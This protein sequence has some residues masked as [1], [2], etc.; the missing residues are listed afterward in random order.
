M[1]YLELVMR[2]T[3]KIK[4]KSNAS[5]L[6]RAGLIAGVLVA[7]AA[8]PLAA[9]LGLVAKTGADLLN[10]LPNE[11]KL[12]PPAQTSYVYAS[13]GKT[14]LTTFYEEHRKY[15]PMSDMSPYILQAIVA[16][17]DSRFYQHGGVDP[18]GVV[19]AFVANQQAGGVSQGAST[20]TMQFV[21]ATLRDGAES[22][23]QVRAATA[24]T[25]GRKVRE[26]RLAMEL[27]K[28]LSKP[29]ILERYLNAAYYGHRAYGI[30]AAAEVF[31]SKH[32][33][34]LNLQEAALLAGLVKAPTA[35]DP[36]SS[37]QKAATDRRNYVI[38]RMK[39]LAYI[40][41]E[42]ATQAK[43]DSIK[44][45]LSMPPNDCAS[46]PEDR[47]SWGFFCDYLKN[48]WV[49]QPAFGN[50]PA[51]REN[52]LNRG[53]YK[54]VLSLDPKI[55]EDAMKSVLAK[56]STSSSY[57]HGVV[58]V[59]PR[60]GLVKTMAVNRVYSLDQ[61]NN[62]SHSDPGL[63]GKVRGNYPNTV[64]A[65]LGGGSLPGYQAGSTFKMFTMLAALN[66]G[67]KLSTAYDSPH[68]Y[69]SIYRTGGGPCGE[70]WCPSNASAAM[71]GRQDMRSGFGKSVNTYFVQLLQSV[72]A[73]KA[74][75]MAER[76]GL[77]WHTDVDKMM[78][79]PGRANNWG[80]FTLGVADTTP[81]EMAN[82]YAAV[83][84]D[85]LYCE[86]LPVL[87]ITNPD[88]SPAMYTNGEGNSVPVAAPRCSQAFSNDAARAATEAARCVTA[89]IANGCGGWSTA[90]QVSGAVGRP[91]AGKTGT[92]DDTRAAWFVGY[93]P[94]LAAASFI[95]D[96]DNPF[97]VVGDGN[98]NKPIDTVSQTLKEAL[99]GRPVTQF[100][101]PPGSIV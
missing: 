50:S 29:E 57:A 58:A 71:T 40:S 10:G 27:E 46:V 87:S 42:T 75:R 31:F 69:Q 30:Y 1:S 9:A 74:V 60:T 85:G 86:A 19:R 90:S 20:L 98:A 82:A 25:P 101:A 17:E 47:N 65:L 99:N 88:G 13:D 63:R 45:N 61:S 33:K 72:G 84:G 78:A 11:L 91:V 92:T 59:E 4:P 26:M 51:E 54:I 67:Y 32:P 24:Q 7:V 97:H 52:K 95:S 28:R 76:L 100:P 15:I 39:D 96:P 34:D 5:M 2:R 37:D 22:P 62:G 81:L 64:N 56:E 41:P 77:T 8:F 12:T 70:Y 66:G 55:Q 36:A 49:S 23:E 6:V 73:E 80:S 3:H 48:W 35:F 16:S 53:G 18:R 83:A 38:D 44:L 89:S 94:E 93:T 14:L 68:R 79:A 43:S 21:R